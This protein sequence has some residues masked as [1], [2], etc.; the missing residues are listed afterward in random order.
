[1]RNGAA[2]DRAI[3]GRSAAFASIATAMLLVGL[4]LWAVWQTDSMALLG[5]LADSALDLVASLATLTGVIIAARPADRTHRFGHG[6]AEALAAIFQVMLIA[7][8][9]TG[10]AMRSGQALIGGERVAA[11]QEGIVVSVIAILATFALLAYQRFVI[12]RT[13]SV[14]IH[15]DHVHY[16]SDLLLNLAVIVALVLDRYVGVA[17]A[18]P[19]FGL[20]IAAWLLWGAWRAGAEAIDHL[21]DRE[22]PEDKRRRFVAVAA[23]HPE[24]SR[25]HDLRTRTSGGIDFVQFHV[26]LPGDYTVEKAHDIIERVEQD[27]HTEFPDAEVLIHIDPEGHVDDPA[28]TLVE[29]D[30]F[31][32]LGETVMNPDTNGKPE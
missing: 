25:L 16:Q 21:M 20:A 31:K 24:L 32:K 1:M 10:I 12:A 30:Q 11:A 14:A 5:S 15:A 13:R 23:R 18:D 28:N 2:S 17:G 29:E 8:S 9:A 26:D 27:L 6:K 7:V 19:L 22:W 4:K 3:L